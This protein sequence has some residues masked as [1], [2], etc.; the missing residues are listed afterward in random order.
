M[1]GNFLGK[2]Q[3]LGKALM[4]PVAVMPAAALLLRLGSGDVLDLPW[5]ANAGAA[6]FNNLPLL[7]AIGIAIGLADEN[8]GVAG[9]AAAVG[10]WVLTLVATTFDAG[11]NM[12]VLAGIIAG[13]IAAMMYNKYKAV[14]LPD[15]LGFFGGR[16]FVPIITSFVALILG[17]IA[18]FVWPLIQNYIS[19]FGNVIATS[20]AV[21][22]FFFGFLNRLL[23]PFG[24]HHVINSF[25]WFQFGE[26]V[27][28]AGQTITGDLSRFFAGDP[29][30]GVFMTG[31]FPIMMFG[32]PAACLAMIATAKPENRKSVA[33]MLLGVA[34]TSFL[35]GI[36]EPIEFLFMFLAPVL[37]VLHA[38]LSGISLALTNAL[39]MRCGF[40][41]S[42]GFIDYFLNFGISANP[43]GLLVV[44]VVF[45]VIYYLVFVY[46]IKKLDIPTPGRITEESAVLSG[47]SNTELRDRAAEVLAALGGKENIKV[48]DACVTRIR[49]TAID[50]EKVDEARLRELGATAVL[51]LPGNNFQIVVG[52]VAD[53]LVTHMKAVM[54]AKNIS[55]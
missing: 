53:P 25:A 8:N 31:F 3:R 7:F 24:L 2:L 6:V 26:Y 38:L 40:G 35:T 51:K 36:T 23:I 20:G 47:L 16:R 55:G 22:G 15:F 39:G 34:F 46:F 54:T 14:R 9:L 21:G 32:L 49:I 18:G 33:G 41:F 19:T 37:Y 13:L 12:G 30:A 52:T 5:M 43:I 29:T 4:T 10:Y 11:I 17:V 50:G 28:A 44:G 42:A 45:G 1:N 27:N 48:I